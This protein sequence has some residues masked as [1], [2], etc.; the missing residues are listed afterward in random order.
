M[1]FWDLNPS[2]REPIENTA[3]PVFSLR[4]VMVCRRANK[5]MR[6]ARGIQTELP[7]SLSRHHKK[8]LLI[9]R[10]FLWYKFLG[11]EPKRARTDRKHRCSGVFVVSGDGLSPSKQAYAKCARHTNRTP[12]VPQIGSSKKFCRFNQSRK[13]FSRF[14]LI[15]KHFYTI[16]KTD[17]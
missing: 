16:L 12:Q 2:G 9:R 10:F 17:I 5:P 8:N 7:K 4:A 1:N 13:I 11:L 6:S 3:A 14:K 15:F